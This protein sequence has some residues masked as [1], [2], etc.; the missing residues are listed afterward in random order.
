MTQHENGVFEIY[1]SENEEWCWR[2]KA[3][4][5][6]VIVNGSEGFKTKQD[7]VHSIYVA[8]EYITRQ[9]MGGRGVHCDIH[10]VDVDGNETRYPRPLREYEM[11]VANEDG[12]GAVVIRDPSAVLAAKAAIMKLSEPY[13]LDTAPFNDSDDP[14]P[15]TEKKVAKK[16][17]AKKKVAKKKVTTHQAAID[18]LPETP[19]TVDIPSESPD[20]NG[21]QSGGILEEPKDLDTRIIG[22]GE[23]SSDDFAKN[24]LLGK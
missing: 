19:D 16:K 5:N 23:M 21:I 2:L 17:V 11:V 8:A 24:L 1:R 14:K 7:A 10:E 9:V 15:V 12:P 22:P 13:V 3:V 18:I 20:M 6:R 4:N